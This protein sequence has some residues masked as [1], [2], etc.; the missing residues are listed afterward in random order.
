MGTEGPYP[1]LPIGSR[2][3]GRSRPCCGCVAISLFLGRGQESQVCGHK[4]ASLSGPLV[5]HVH[6]KYH[7]KRVN[8]SIF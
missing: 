8:I 1:P 4:G 3:C 5:V 7:I 6:G 2:E